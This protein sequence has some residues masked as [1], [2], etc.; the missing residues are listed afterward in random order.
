MS[1]EAKITEL[2]LAVQAL[3]H[4]MKERSEPLAFQALTLAMKERQEPVDMT[5]VA[6]PAA[7]VDSY[8]EPSPPNEF[9]SQKSGEQ[10]A[11]AH[12]PSS[13]ALTYDDVKRATNNLSAAKG[14]EIT[15]AALARF[16]VN[17]ATELTE[18]QWPEYC[19]YTAD[20]AVGKI[21]PRKAA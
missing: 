6:I 4:A 11:P 13:P 10:S 2:T 3:T 15:I 20:C 14:K 1:L 9:T 5:G 7:P 12:E 16:G 18:T 8:K 17:R 19:S 21:D